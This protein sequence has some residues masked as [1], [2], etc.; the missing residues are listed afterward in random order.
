MPTSVH[1][2][3]TLNNIL[4]RVASYFH[5]IFIIIYDLNGNW[6]TIVVRCGDIR[7]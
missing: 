3:N 5:I 6:R 2:H 1:Q 7:I 4:I